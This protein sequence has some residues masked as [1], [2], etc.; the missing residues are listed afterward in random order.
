MPSARRPPEHAM[1]RAP[2][3]RWALAYPASLLVSGLGAALVLAVLMETGL[4]VWLALGMMGAGLSAWTLLEYL[5]HRFLLH[6]VEPFQAWHGQHHL[7][8]GEPIRIPLAFSVPLMLAM[9]VLP[10]LLLRNVALGAAVSIGLLVGEIAQQTVHRRLHA[11]GGGRWLGVLR[12]AHAFH[13]HQDSRLGFGT[14]SRFWDRCFGTA[15]PL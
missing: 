12:A 11:E 6:G 15:P 9:L 8:P 3:G 4:P 13:H 14:L 5:L 1:A 7:M 2:S 10:S